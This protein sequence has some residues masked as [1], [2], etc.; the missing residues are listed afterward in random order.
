MHKT[1]PRGE[2]E[3]Q[4]TKGGPAGD[5]AAGVV[6]IGGGM[7]GYEV[8]TKLV[9]AGLGG[10]VTVIQGN[11]FSEWPIHQPYFLTRP[12]EYTR[13]QPKVGSATLDRIGIPGVTY[14]VGHVRAIE[15][16]AVVL[17]G[18]GSAWA[19]PALSAR[20]PEGRIRF[21]V[22]VI[23]TGHHQPVIC[24][25]PG[26]DQAARTAAIEQFSGVL[27]SEKTKR[28]LVGG[29]GPVAVEMASEARRVNAKAEITMVFPQDKPFGTAWTGQASRR[30]L[31]RLEA[32][33]IKLMPNERLKDVAPAACFGGGPFMTESGKQL[34]ADVLLPYFGI[35]RTE[36][37]EASIPGSTT[38]RG[39]VKTKPNGQLTLR[40]DIFA[41]GV[42]DRFP[43]INVMVIKKEADVVA[44][45][46]AAFV[47]GGAALANKKTL[48]D[49][50]GPVAPHWIHAPLNEWTLVNFDVKGAPPACV[51]RC[52]GICNPLC[53]C[54]CPCF[55]W[56]CAYPAGDLPSKGMSAIMLKMGL[57][58]K[59]HNAK[60]PAMAE[61]ER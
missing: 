55:G 19:D 61:M 43:G 23:A 26:Q 59:V 8:A 24:P 46:V 17:G 40:D 4:E 39:R 50:A 56:C 29:G 21:R 9:R 2:E 41:V 58:F 47:K 30:L 12:D 11:D 54:C 37:V 45:N 49:V 22:L 15:E 33:N 31:R 27:A 32:I 35:P 7:A 10:Q 57:P 34:E 14:C 28:I 13:L 18:D 60:P 16:G 1:A 48:P 3:E 25:E 53:P 5:A 51:A 52:C 6:I 42:S 38:E 44:A 20:L 36:F